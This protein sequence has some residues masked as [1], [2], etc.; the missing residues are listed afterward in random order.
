MEPV[1]G[2]ANLKPGQNLS[3]RFDEVVQAQ[4]EIGR[5]LEEDVRQALSD[6]GLGD[7]VNLNVVWACLTDTRS[8]RAGSSKM[9]L[10]NRQTRLDAY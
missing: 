6:L 2:P 10:R 5:H 4:G 1:G 3:L 9:H 8:M 7:S